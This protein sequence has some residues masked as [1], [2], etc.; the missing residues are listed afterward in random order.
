MPRAPAVKA[1]PPPARALKSPS[2][3]TSA[4]VLLLVDFINPLDFP[5]GAEHS[6]PRR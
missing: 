3:P 1:A 5:G 4:R 6:R 2:L